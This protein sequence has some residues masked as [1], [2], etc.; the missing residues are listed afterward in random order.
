MP[1]ST[2]V[3]DYIERRQQMVL[4]Q[5]AE[6]GIQDPR[7]LE[8]MAE[9]PR[10]RFVAADLRHLAYE[11]C[12]LP[13]AER[14]TISQ[15]YMVAAMCEVLRLHGDE[16]VL[17]IGT[18]S[19]YAAA[20]LSRL[21]RRVISVERH[22]ALAERAAARL[23]E[24]GYTNIT[25]RLGDGTRGW[26]A[27]APFDAITVTAGA[28]AVPEA[29]T[30]QLADGGRLVIPVGTE[31]EQTLLRLTRCGAHIHREELMPCVFVPLI[32]AGGWEG[33]E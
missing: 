1:E 16:T 14:Q 8:A 30:A 18:G 9:V 15:P 6:R 13:I 32:G 22:P 29:L 23:W 28:P 19:G 7:V 21:V 26:R 5:L 20:V 10:E 4:H 11:D 31:R 27:D 33:Q 12:A 3:E 17:E 25:V 24:L 2:R